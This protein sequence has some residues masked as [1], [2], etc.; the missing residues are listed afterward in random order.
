M[1]RRQHCDNYLKEI[2]A[3]G[4]EDMLKTMLRTI[5][6]EVM[7]EEMSRHIGAER[8]ERNGG[9]RGQ[10]NGCKARTLINPDNAFD[11]G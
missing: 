1:A 3:H 9:R 7:E 4:S 2:Q 10:R 8:H 6:Q 5:M 11:T